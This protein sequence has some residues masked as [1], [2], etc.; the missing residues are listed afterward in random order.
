MPC[1][2]QNQTRKS[3]TSH[4]VTTWHRFETPNR[5]EPCICARCFRNT[6]TQRRSSGESLLPRLIASPH[7]SLSFLL[8]V[9][10]SLIPS[11][12]HIFCLLSRSYMSPPFTKASLNPH[13]APSLPSLLHGILPCLSTHTPQTHTMTCKRRRKSHICRQSVQRVFSN[14]GFRSAPPRHHLSCTHA[15]MI[16]GHVEPRKSSQLRLAPKNLCTFCN[17]QQASYHGL[18]LWAQVEHR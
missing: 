1:W 17:C 2:Q 7:P 16:R 8:F 11:F 15:G 9:F 13:A 5:P 3:C 18:W 14:C 6:S 4:R 12:L 10:L